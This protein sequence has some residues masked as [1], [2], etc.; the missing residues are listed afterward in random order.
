MRQ[1]SSKQVAV[2]TGASS[3][4]G[5]A[6]ALAFAAEGASLAMVGR[7]RETLLAVARELPAGVGEVKC[8]VADLTNDADL[9]AFTAQVLAD[10]ER[11]DFLVHSAALLMRARLDVATLA[12]FDL[13]YACNVRAPF[14]ITQKFLPSLLEHQGGVIFINS[15]AGLGAKPDMGQYAATK[16]ALKAIADGLRQEVAASGLRVLS[17]FLGRTATPM[18]AA[19]CE[20]EGKSYDPTLYIQPADVAQS[21]LATLSLPRSAEITDLTLRPTR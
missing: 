6:V 18:Q 5:K 1:F 13:Q 14:A 17:I 3:G 15:S 4:V 11:V 20:S 8:Y 7:D 2:V 12:D 16:H 21:I 9:A 19:L 10:F